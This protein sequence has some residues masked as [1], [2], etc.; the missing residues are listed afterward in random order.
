MIIPKADDRAARLVQ[1]GS[2]TS[3]AASNTAGANP[4]ASNPAARMYVRGKAGIV[5][6]VAASALT[7]ILTPFGE[8]L[9]PNA[10]RSMANSSGP[11]ALVAFTAIYF[12]SLRGW[13][14]AIMGVVSF[15]TMDLSFYVVFESLGMFYPHH[16]LAF[17][18]GVGAL[19]GP[20]IGLAASWLRADDIV[21]RA[22]AVAAMPAVLVGEGVFMLVRL[23][24]ESTVYAIASLV[25]G[26]G[27]FVV[28]SRFLL[29]RARPIAMSLAMGLGGAAAFFF[30]YGLIPLL[31][32]K[33]VP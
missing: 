24:G 28:A 19:I 26:A 30:V 8:Q 16:F 13:R 7:G 18:I 9:L 22:V 14:A 1:A 11:W 4:A 17:W 29:Q 2:V 5:T 6:V 20:V 31:L 15:L 12:S 10:V 21:P 3:P 33:V 23:P 27:V 32:N 25:V